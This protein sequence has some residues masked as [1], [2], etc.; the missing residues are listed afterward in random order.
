MFNVLED[1]A[2]FKL[3]GSQ[4][5]GCR[6]A[7]GDLIG[8]FLFIWYLYC[9]ASIRECGGWCVRQGCCPPH[10]EIEN[11]EREGHGHVG[12][13]TGE[14]CIGYGWMAVLLVSWSHI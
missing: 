7:K 2:G 6:Y 8:Y 5:T 4:S 12:E 13:G 14:D 11:R 10:V 9:D 1:L 3:S